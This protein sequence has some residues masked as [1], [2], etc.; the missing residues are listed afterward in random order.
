MD[1]PVLANGS[2]PVSLCKYLHR[3]IID[4]PTH[5]RWSPALLQ[6]TLGQR[7]ALTE[8]SFHTA[9]EEL[10]WGGTT[11]RNVVLSFCRCEALQVSSSRSVLLCVFSC[12]GAEQRAA[13]QTCRHHGE[14]LLF[15]FY[16]KNI[17]SS[18][19][20][21]KELINLLYDILKQL[22]LLSIKMRKGVT[23]DERVLKHGCPQ[24]VLFVYCWQ[25]GPVSSSTNPIYCPTPNESHISRITWNTKCQILVLHGGRLKLK[26]MISNS[27]KT[28]NKTRRFLA[29]SWFFSRQT[30]SDWRHGAHHTVWW[31]ADLWADGSVSAV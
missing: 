16:C 30:R 18:L 28:S 17:L 5:S 21:L 22:Q 29:N 10:M 4:G 7:M 20:K 15:F 13:S 14:S 24:E 11:Q 12:A 1:S 25:F 31:A 8:R 6:A 2:S 26:Y 27:N 23:S 19:F 9:W 3:G